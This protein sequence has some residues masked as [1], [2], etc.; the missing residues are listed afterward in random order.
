MRL[1]HLLAAVGVVAVMLGLLRWGPIGWIL[2]LEGGA[3]GLI[4]LSPKIQTW[5]DRLEALDGDD[6]SVGRV[7]GMYTSGL[8][9]FL[10]VVVAGIWIMTAVVVL[11]L[12]ALGALYFFSFELT[13][14]VS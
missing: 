12:A 5:A 7:V 9:L 1:W 11:L 13:R 4:R 3:Y 8:L 14:Y 6:Q 2:L 10:F